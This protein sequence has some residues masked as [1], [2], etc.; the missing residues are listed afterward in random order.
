MQI[1]AAAGSGKTEVVSQRVASLLADGEPAE[2][3][4]AFTF[5]E[6]AA[7]ELK[8]RIRQRV[9]GRSSA[10][11][12]TDQLGRLFVGTIHAYCFRLLQTH[13]PRVRDLHAARREPARQPALPRGRT[14]SSSSS[15]TRTA[16]CS[17]AS[18]A[19]QRERRR[20]RERAARLDDLPDGVPGRRSSA[21]Y[22]MLDRYRFMSFGTQI[23]R[24]VE[25]LEDPDV[26]ATVTADLRHL[27]V[28]EYQDVNPAQ[29]RLI[30]LLAKPHGTADLVV[31]GDDDQ[32]IYQWRGSNVDNIVD[33]RRPLR[34]RHAV[35]PARQPALAARRSSSS[36]TRS[37]RR[38]PGG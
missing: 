23:V 34:R 27:I 14:G 37:P 21:Y 19:F 35:Q 2:S 15:S 4:V 22:A 32:A 7:A 18:S 30:E 33:L 31:V 24:A 25:A 20:R 12:A 6:K 28:D 36:R 8:E 17:A 11:A 26:H 38:S 1:I 13:V 5:T 10:S 29:E 3:I 16:S 9:D